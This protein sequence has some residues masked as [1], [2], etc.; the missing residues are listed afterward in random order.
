VRRKLQVDSLALKGASSKRTVMIKLTYKPAIFMTLGFFC[1]LIIWV[2]WPVLVRGLRDDS[3][4]S[5][6]DSA[7][8]VQPETST[9]PSRKQ[10]ESD[11]REK[12]V[13][14]L[15]ADLV[16]AGKSMHLSLEGTDHTTIRMVG[17]DVDDK[18]PLIFFSTKGLCDGLRLAH[19]KNVIF[20]S[21]GP[22]FD[23]AYSTELDVVT[24]CDIIGGAKAYDRLTNPH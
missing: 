14:N 5:T 12:W 17:V 10:L 20:V 19:F 6:N 11:T 4:N 16:K 22:V 3:R 1:V 24:T 23:G 21:S 9:E 18:M 15:N 7:Q 13:R 8:N 2:Y